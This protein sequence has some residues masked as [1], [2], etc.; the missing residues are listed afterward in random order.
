MLLTPPCPH[1]LHALCFCCSCTPP[2]PTP[3]HTRSRARTHTHLRS[4]APAVPVPGRLFPRW[5]H[6]LLCSGLRPQI[7][8]DPSGKAA[9]PSVLG[10]IKAPATLWLQIVFVQGLPPLLQCLLPMA[11]TWSWSP[12]YRRCLARSRHSINAH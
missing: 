5:S 12:A 8:S 7:S 10:S 4:C 2:T 1:L 6:G 11:A 9:A 3:A